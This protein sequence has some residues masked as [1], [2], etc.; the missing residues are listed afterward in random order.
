M[1][2]YS[3]EGWLAMSV[4]VPLLGMAIT[5]KAQASG[6]APAAGEV[7]TFSLP[8]LPYAQDALEPHLSARTLSVHYG[9]HHQAYVDNLNKLAAA[10][11]MAGRPLEEII[12]RTGNLRR[13]N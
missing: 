13:H 5:A 7:Q 8:A 9:K 3:R 12:W 1:N 10:A 4:L 2:P 6:K 11:K